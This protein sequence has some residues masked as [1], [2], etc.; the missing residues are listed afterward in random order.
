[1][2]PLLEWASQITAV[3]GFKAN[4]LHHVPSSSSLGWSAQDWQELQCLRLGSLG[5]EKIAQ[6]GQGRPG[7]LLHW[8][9]GKVPAGDKVPLCFI[10]SSVL[11][12]PLGI[13]GKAC[14]CK[15]DLDA[16]TWAIC[17]F[18]NTHQ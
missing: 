9:L 5:E 8:V 7:S 15:Q 11:I 18:I 13:L 2:L 1:M 16:H 4:T 6:H 10:L 14:H 12:F 3:L 17:E